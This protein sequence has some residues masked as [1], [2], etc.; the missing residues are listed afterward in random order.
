MFV[1]IILWIL[2]LAVFWLISSCLAH[3]YFRGLPDAGFCFALSLGL[4]C[5]FVPYWI[6]VTLLPF[7]H[8]AVTMLSLGAF[9]GIFLLIY[10]RL[11]FRNFSR[12]LSDS[13]YLVITAFSIF[14]VVF[15]IG[16]FIR[17]H[18]GFVYHTEQPMD[19]AFLNALITSINFPPHDPWMTGH[20]I[21]Y[22]YFGYLIFGS[23]GKLLALDGSVVYNLAL[24]TVAALS[25]VGIFGLT[26]NLVKLSD[27][28][29]KFAY[30][31][32]FFA[33]LLL[34]AG[35][36]EGVLEYMQAQALGSNGFWSFVDVGG[37]SSTDS[38]LGFYPERHWWWFQASRILPGGEIS[39]FPFFSLVL[40]DLHPHVMSIPFFILAISLIF[41]LYHGQVLGV[42]GRQWF[43]SNRYKLLLV[44]LAIG[45]CG[46]INIAD[47]PVLA[48]LF[49]LILFIR[50]RSIEK[51]DVILALAKSAITTVA[52]IA[53][54]LV[55]FSPF[56]FSFTSNINGI[57]I[58]NLPS[59][60]IVHIFL[61][62]GLFIAIGIMFFIVYIT[63]EYGPRLLR[64]RDSAA[65]DLKSFWSTISFRYY[66][67]PW[68]NKNFP[69][70][71]FPLAVSFLFISLVNLLLFGEFIG[72]KGGTYILLSGVIIWLLLLAPAHFIN[73]LKRP[74][75]FILILLLV[76]TGLIL[77]PE[78]I[79]INDV[80]SS[81][82]NTVFK[83]YYQAWI[84]LSCGI[85]FAL[86]YVISGIFQTN[87][88]LKN[89]YI[90]SLI[91]IVLLIL[92]A[93]YY[94]LAASLSRIEHEK[95][96]EW[97][98]SALAS[99]IADT[100]HDK[101]VIHY[102]REVSPE[103]TIVEAVGNDYSSYGRIASFTG[104][105]SIIAWPGHQQQWNRSGDEISRR[106]IDVEAIYKDPSVT[107]IKQL[108]DRYDFDFI[109][110]GDREYKQYGEIN[111]N[112]F[113]E[114]AINCSQ[115]H[116]DKA[117]YRNGT[118]VI[119]RVD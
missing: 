25:A 64:Y 61:I 4:L 62:W 104:L 85:A 46:F 72:S 117:C 7:P 31:A 47:M 68:T 71:F 119:Y 49:G 52:M 42:F 92:P 106:I 38:T 97:N 111:L 113:E 112:R 110:V 36:L 58:N 57:V 11:N 86:V 41:N 1:Q 98:I 93:V 67:I 76:S 66:L 9:Y 43:F 109:V 115:Q 78:V 16:I 50:L 95:T 35:N 88:V 87:S 2:L 55:C 91:P 73:P 70:L 99:T 114:L 59:S 37:L 34:F 23:L 80:F 89:I 74:F 101:D 48:L 12:F 19:L 116:D 107:K 39:E 24:P 94:P 15:A 3:R 56:Y 83:L 53:L 5:Y 96:V 17:G 6:I 45:G 32:G 118:T 81:R 65:Y 108:I 63:K 29:E 22:Y 84:L 28:T 27:I 10:L 60:R 103:S 77:I 8:H 102:L 30:P 33:V 40:G 100:N 26:Y 79:Y 21:N 18:I 69:H 44:S 20:S 13:R 105:S 14:A 90:T 51:V 82:M 54:V 75:L